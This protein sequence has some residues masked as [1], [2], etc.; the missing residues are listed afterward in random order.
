M[1]DE[2]AFHMA[3]PGRVVSAPVLLCWPD[4]ALVFLR[5]RSQAL[6]SELLQALAFEGLGRI[7]VAFRIE[8]DVVHP[9]ELARLASA[10]A[11][12]GQFFERIAQQDV[13]PRVLSV[14]QKDL[15]L[16]GILRESDVPSR[17]AS[18]RLPGDERLFH[19]RAVLV[20]HLDPVVRPVAGVDQPIVRDFGGTAS[21]LLAVRPGAVER[22]S[23]QSRRHSPRSE[24]PR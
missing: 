13:H 14:G 22:P 8:S 9:E 3:L 18:T 5:D 17:P 6:V 23:G 21:G 11:K 12:V 1:R 20:E 15:G 4:D 24:C 10:V 2:R 7:E 19:I 16:L